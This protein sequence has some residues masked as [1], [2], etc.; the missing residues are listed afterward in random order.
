MSC[1]FE[2]L[3][4]IEIKWFW[5]WI[6]SLFCNYICTIR[7]LAN[8]RTRTQLF[9]SDVQ[10]L[11]LARSKEITSPR[12]RT[13][14]EQRRSQERITC[15]VLSYAVHTA[16][17]ERGCKRQNTDDAQVTL[18]SCEKVIPRDI[19]S[20]WLNFKLGGQISIVEAGDEFVRDFEWSGNLDS[21]HSNKAGPTCIVFFQKE[22]NTAPGSEKFFFRNWLLP[23]KF[24]GVE[25]RWD[26]VGNR[27][28]FEHLDNWSIMFDV[29]QSANQD[30][31]T[32]LINL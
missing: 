16:R 14:F 17:P 11:K 25:L 12:Y 4:F 29:K 26:D 1:L 30:W 21:A 24:R 7:Q 23:L 18:P 9:S 6:F 20:N 27:Q 31:C 28:S 32:D 2:S 10:R 8:A 19:L 15:A 5:F 13:E 22:E 3:L